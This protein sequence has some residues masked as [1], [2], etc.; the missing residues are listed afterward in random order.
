MQPPTS[1]SVLVLPVSITLELNRKEEGAKNI[2]R[3]GWCVPYSI[4]PPPVS[5]SVHA[6]SIARE[7]CY[8]YW[9]FLNDH[10]RIQG[11]N[12][13]LFSSTPDEAHCISQCPL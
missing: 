3:E 8:V 6:A 5:L 1:R 13:C 10:I 11:V 4:C 2:L 9:N 12:T 7:L